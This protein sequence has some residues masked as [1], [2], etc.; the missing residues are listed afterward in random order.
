MTGSIV[1][2]VDLWVFLAL[3][4][5]CCMLHLRELVKIPISAL[6]MLA[7]MLLRGVGQYM[8]VVESAVLVMDSVEEKTILLIFLPPLIAEC[9]FST[10]WYT[11]KR[12][13][14]QII[15]LAT[16][17]VLVS[18]VLTALVIRYVLGFSDVFDWYT[19]F[20]LG[21][22]LS[23]TDHVSVV[24]QLKEVNADYRLETLI[25]GETLVN[26]GS[27]IVLFTAMMNG[28]AESSIT[29]GDI[30][31]QFFRL[32]LGGILLG[33]GF[34]VALSLWLKRL[35]NNDT[36]EILLTVITTYL[37][38]FTAE[39]TNLHV[40]GGIAT[41]TFGLYM[42]AY[43]KTLISPLIE[44]T[45]HDFWKILGTIIESLIIVL[46]GTLAARFFSDFESLEYADI[47][48]LVALF[49]L[50]HVVRAVTVLIHWPLLRKMGYGCTL[51]EMIVLIVG[52]LKG[53]ISIALALMVFHDDHFSE[54]VRD[55]I[56]FWSVGISAL[57]V[58]LDS[59]LMRF[60]VRYLG[61]ESMTG[62]E[63][64]ML[65]SVSTS[66]LESTRKNMNK[67]KEDAN[68]AMVNWD[69]V[70]KM[71]GPEALFM[72][73]LRATKVG[74]RLLHQ[75]IQG[76]TSDILLRFGQEVDISDDDIILETRRRYYTT[77]K[78]LYWDQ[79]EH[80]YCFGDSAV[81]LIESA[82][83]G[84]DNE[85]EPMMDWCI[86][87]RT[88]Y[89]QR[90]MRFLHIASRL[91]VLGRYFQRLEYS[92]IAQA[93][94][95][96]RNFIS[97]HKEAEV[98]LDDLEIDIKK[99]VFERVM[100]EPHAQ[101]DLAEAFLTEYIVDIYPEV[102]I[103]VQTKQA[104]SAL[105]YSEKK[106]VEEAYDQGVITELEFT[107]LSQSLT[108]K[109]TKLHLH[110]APR[111]LTITDMLRS[112]SLFK[113]L[114]PSDLSYLVSQTREEI[115]KQGTVIYENKAVIEGAIVVLKGRIR[116]KGKGF[117][118]E[119]YPGDIV[120]LQ[121]LLPGS[122]RTKT[123]ACA[124][125]QSTL[126]FLP[127]EAIQE[128]RKKASFDRV[129]CIEGIKRAVQVSKELFGP[130]G[131][132]EP[133]TLSAVLANCAL[134]K[135]VAGSEV[136]LT[137]GS[138][139]LEGKLSNGFRAFAFIE[140]REEAVSD[141]VSDCVLLQFSA[142]FGA[143]VRNFSLDLAQAVN[144]FLEPEEPRIPRIRLL[145][146]LQHVAQP[147]LQPESSDLYSV[148][149]KEEPKEDEDV[150]TERGELPKIMEGKR[151][152]IL[153]MSSKMDVTRADSS[154]MEEEKE[155]STSFISELKKR[156]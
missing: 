98:L 107:A 21:A 16:S 25:Q 30:A 9:A 13:L 137:S 82:N 75:G 17:A 53:T 122:V 105:L 41:V 83:R 27:V 150:L 119:H 61:L 125:I 45:F 68:Y 67:M 47:G 19:A 36:L 145:S 127:H 5:S 39:A 3:F 110:T 43:G 28:V 14:G 117:E 99:D 100:K 40:S 118:R 60:T 104:S 140:G 126:A 23:A 2:E 97:A 20:L 34:S 88:I 81:L 113:E 24:A 87:H 84:L 152:K 124:T 18:S 55:L 134:V 7:G 80:G 135:A 116:E 35:V 108:Q 15:L 155:D 89:P 4:L 79:F 73:M 156:I 62:V 144:S 64:N 56:F 131:L 31:A 86:V 141:A 26:E 10:D 66:I 132:L 44:K 133:A 37:L 112:C 111:P 103:Y 78:G 143:H 121:D 59:M 154:R 91:P 57:S 120:G 142:E 76:S 51:K 129:L 95:V 128:L 42:S 72:D 149:S 123:S 109:I 94:D 29:A 148:G 63:E 52:A 6:L 153:G 1:E 85:I 151:A 90:L 11:I 65:V 50:L 102:S 77:L 146:L 46:G 38:F 101:N 114:S 138:I 96:C 49:V 33:M 93:Y 147:H 92:Y 71:A 74:Q 8:N 48:Y 54:R 106:F 130:L 70:E 69:E 32:S 58:I 22:I 139:L 136:S 12:E 115:V